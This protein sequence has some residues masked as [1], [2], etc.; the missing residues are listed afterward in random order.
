MFKSYLFAQDVCIVKGPCHL[1]FVSNWQVSNELSARVI[2]ERVSSAS[3]ARQQRVISVSAAVSSEHT[4]ST[5][6]AHHR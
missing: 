5:R 2:S 6:L 1:L 3:A 4:A